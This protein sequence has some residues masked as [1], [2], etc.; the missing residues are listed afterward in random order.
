MADT[1]CEKS[2]R[3]TSSS[4]RRTSKS[5]RAVKDIHGEVDY[6]AIL[7][8][9]SRLEVGTWS[10]NDGDADTAKHIGPYAEDF[11]AAFKVGDGACINHTDAFGVLFAGVKALA[12]RVKELE[13]KLAEKAA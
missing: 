4:T 5:S 1:S 10:Y 3:W 7:T 13:E 8:E 12:A 6:S 2:F 9:L 11:R